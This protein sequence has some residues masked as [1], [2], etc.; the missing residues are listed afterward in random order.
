MLTETWTMGHLVGALVALA[1]VNDVR[2]LE[3]E[4]NPL[5]APDCP[6]IEL[7]IATEA[8]DPEHSLATLVTRAD[9]RAHLRSPGDEIAGKRLVFV[10][11][12]GAR[13]SPAAWLA[14][15]TELC[16]A[17]LF[18]RPAVAGGEPR[19]RHETVRSEAG[20]APRTSRLRVVPVLRSGSVVG[21]RLLGLAPG[22]LLGALGLENGDTLES[23]N[24]FELGTPEQALRAYAALRQAERLS[25]KLVRRGRPMTIDF[26]IR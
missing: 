12:N 14:S 11:Y 9:A 24:G 16:Q 5:T 20:L 2:T 6:G 25:V 26:V 3:A 21:V 1:P 10:G 19:E 4:P 8:S 22:G 17:L 18:E 23:V 7:V 15:S 13:M